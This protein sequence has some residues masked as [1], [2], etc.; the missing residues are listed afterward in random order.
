MGAP[1]IS[2]IKSVLPSL[3]HTELKELKLLSEHLLGDYPK[4]MPESPLSRPEALILAQLETVLP[5]SISQSYKHKCVRLL[6]EKL[7]NLE[8]ARRIGTDKVLKA[9]DLV[10][11]AVLSCM[12]EDHIAL[13]WPNFRFEI[14]HLGDLLERQYPHYRVTGLLTK[15]IA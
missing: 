9:L 7:N 14:E 12:E 4:V 15:A 3:S 13:T 5:S 6:Y 2:E 1:S 8:L 10:L 11:L